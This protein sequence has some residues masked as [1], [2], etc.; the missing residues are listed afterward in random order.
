MS[1]L[2]LGIV[3]EMSILVTIGGV[4]KYTLNF[5][6]LS[7]GCVSCICRYFYIPRLRCKFSYIPNN[8]FVQLNTL[9]NTPNTVTIT[10]YE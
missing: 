1:R 8:Y 2:E 6:S 10:L 4:S 7:I 3:R 5:K 9:T